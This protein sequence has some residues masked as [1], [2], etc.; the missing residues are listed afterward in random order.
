MFVHSPPRP[1][2]RRE[3]EARAS[4][5]I[6]ALSVLLASLSFAQPAFAQ[7]EA[8]GDQA[9]AFAQ[10]GLKHYESGAWAEALEKF[11]KADARSHSPVFVLYIARSQRSMGRL[12]AA[13][14]TYQRLVAEKLPEGATPSFRQSQADGRAELAALEPTIP[15]VIVRAEGA[16]PA[17]TVTVGGRAASLG[18]PFELDPGDYEI[19]MVD[20]A[21]RLSEKISLKPGER[22]REVALAPEKP[23]GGDP[24]PPVPR[25]EGQ[26][27]SLVPGIVVLSLGGAS[28]IAGAILGGVALSIDGGITDKCPDGACE[29]G[30]DLDQI[31]S[32]KS[33]SLALAHASTGTLIGGGVLA[34]VGVVLLVVR[35]GG[36]E[37]PATVSVGPTAAT[38]TVSF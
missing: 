7:G 22:E 21:R 31:E 37:S 35:P 20:G 10:E 34:A 15:S 11:Q 2:S 36:D 32:D 26:P 17:A 14:A 18:A 24:P 16:S 3:G 5:S 33:T 28:L 9:V 38:L 19:V 27:G 30:T 8:A 23:A 12:L 4:A 6:G 13:R 25:A 1:L 29:P